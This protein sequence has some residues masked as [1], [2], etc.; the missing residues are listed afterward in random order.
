MILPKEGLIDSFGAEYS[1]MFWKV[2]VIPGRDRGR[3]QARIM[4][5]MKLEVGFAGQCSCMWV[6]G[7]FAQ[8]KII[9][10]ILP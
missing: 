10:W 1:V 7:V 6:K 3:I 5:V 4:L 8:K 2:W 9:G